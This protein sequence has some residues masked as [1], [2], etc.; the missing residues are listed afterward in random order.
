M[1]SKLPEFTSDI[2]LQILGPLV[3]NTLCN[4]VCYFLM[5]NITLQASYVHVF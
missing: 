5:F 4:D 2:T 1:S 3:N